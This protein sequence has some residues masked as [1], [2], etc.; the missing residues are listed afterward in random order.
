MDYKYIEQLL[1]RYFECDTTLQEEQILKAFFAQGTDGMPE[2]LAQYAPLF[3]EVSRKDTLGSD[4]DE[5]LIAMTKEQTIVKAR[6]VSMKERLRPLFAAAAMV[7][8][9]LTLGGAINQSFKQDDI[10]VDADH[11]AAVEVATGDAAVAYEQTVADSL[12]F[13]KDVR[14]NTVTDSVSAGILN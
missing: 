8:I 13:G 10:W 12:S 1:E 9:I 7:A 4:F 3:G 14:G 6:V 2:H 5:R 11:Y